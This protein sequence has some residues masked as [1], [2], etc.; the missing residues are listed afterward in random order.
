MNS[1][2]AAR[3][4]NRIFQVCFFVCMAVVFF[5]TFFYG[6]A[7]RMDTNTF[8]D[9]NPKR[10]LYSP[11]MHI[12]IYLAALLLLVFFCV[13]YHFASK[14]Y[15]LK[16]RSKMS[17]EKKYRIILF[18]VVILMLA[19]ELY[20]GWEMRIYRSHDL[21]KVGVNSDVYA[22]TGSFQ[23]LRD[24][25]ANGVNEGIYMARYP[26][27]FAI[28]FFLALLY[29]VWYLMF[30]TIP[31][32]APVVVNCIA[33][34]ASVLFTALIAKQL[35]GRRKSLF[36]LGM[37][38]IF[39][40]FY[41][42][43]PLYYTDTLSMPFGI[44]ALYWIVLAMKKDKSQRV[45][46]YLLLFFAGAMLLIGYKV[47][48]NLAIPLVAAIIYAFAKCKI[49]EFA[50]IAL[51][52][53]LGFGSF[54]VMFKA[55]YNYLNLVSE[56]SVEHYEY[57]YT[58][59][60]MMGLNGLGGYN[61]SDSVFTASI[62]GKKNKQEANIKVIKERVSNHLK[63]HTML[64]HLTTK[65]L[66][67]WTD[68]TYTIPGHLKTY[69]KRSF[70]HQIFLRNGK[71]Y[72]YYFGYASA[73]QLLLT[74][75][76][77]ISAIKG[78]IK[79]KIDFTVLLKLIVFGIFIFLLIWEGRSRY[80]FNLTPIFILVSADGVFCITDTTK[81]LFSK[82]RKK[83][84]SS[85]HVAAYNED[86]SPEDLIDDEDVSADPVETDDSYEE[87]SLSETALQT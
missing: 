19:V 83:S 11:L 2:K 5:G 45:K 32:Y 63:E 67:M 51:A 8:E 42:Y 48:G 4:L 69:V 15:R 59:W 23:E 17:D 81:K 14:K 58:H 20:L 37:M 13:L 1:N 84:A 87:I 85:K 43:V 82:I 65:A 38:V 36:V 34:S 56:E 80:L 57:P 64:D 29:R 46:K 72:K 21:E 52:L 74:F 40:P 76:M 27:N 60:V 28:M 44:I 31:L 62:D 12:L 26:N 78:I 49:K 68:G 77:M 71:Y 16:N 24:R 79:S 41:L 61:K 7:K 6:Y 9:L 25:V 73:Y 39:S 86:D 53:V 55:G 10:V 66:W 75:L 22:K 54:M 35:W 50:C 33:I 30:G 47:K 70:F 18:V 3:V